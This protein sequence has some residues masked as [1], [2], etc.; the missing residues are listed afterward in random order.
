MTHCVQEIGIMFNT[1]LSW[2]SFFF[3]TGSLV[4]QLTLLGQR[5]MQCLW[6]MYDHK[7]GLC[8]LALPHL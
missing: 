3:F 4:F 1:E 8:G 6:R 5:A 7:I 2:T